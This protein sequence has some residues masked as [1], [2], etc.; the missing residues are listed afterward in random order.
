MHPIA[1]GWAADP[2]AGAIGQ[3]GAA[4]EAH[5]PL[6]DPERAAGANTM[7]KGPVLFSGLGVEHTADHLH[8]SL[9]ELTDARSSHPRIRIL[10][11][12]H[13][14]G[15]A[16]LEHGLG[17]RGRPAVMAAGLQRHHQGAAS[18]G[19]TGLGQGTHLRMGLSGT[20]MKALPHQ[21]AV[22]IENHGT[23]Q[24]I[25]TGA[26]LSQRRQGQGPSHPQVPHQLSG[27]SC[28]ERH[29]PTT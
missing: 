17:A 13:H 4:I 3:S 19:I 27:S 11:G 8:S 18:G 23:H 25:G 5:G 6:Q 16:C 15:Q 12:H 26:P 20:G 22:G 9:P 7:Q 24:G 21:G 28:R 14:P 1:G 2:L 10:K 29:S